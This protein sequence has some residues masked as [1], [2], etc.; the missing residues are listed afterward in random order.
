MELSWRYNLND[1]SM[2]FFIQSSKDMYMRIM[3]VER[4]NEEREKQED[5]QKEEETKSNTFMPMNMMGLPNALT[6]GG[7]QNT[8]QNT[9]STT[10][11]IGG[12]SGFGGS[13]NQGNGFAGNQTKKFP[14]IN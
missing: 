12:F 2:P 8:S 14:F 5:K 11:N 1:Y 13:T 3:G 6:Y 9:F 10:S 7:P 4:K